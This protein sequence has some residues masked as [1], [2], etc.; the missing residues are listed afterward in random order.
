MLYKELLQIP[1]EQGKNE[2]KSGQGEFSCEQSLSHS[3]LLLPAYLDDADTHVGT[4]ASQDVALGIER[5]T[6]AGKSVRVPNLPYGFE[7][8]CGKDMKAQVG[9]A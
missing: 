3:W 2:G 5:K 7:T 9:G 6:S 8:D 1:S 4:T